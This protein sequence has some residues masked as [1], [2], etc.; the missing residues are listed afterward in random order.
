MT[1]A[2]SIKEAPSATKTEATKPRG[3]ER[4][5]HDISGP[6]PREFSQSNVATFSPRVRLVPIAIA[7][8][9]YGIDTQAV[10]ARVDNAVHP[11]H[12]RWAFNIGSGRAGATRELRFWVNEIGAP[13]KVKKFSIEQAV[14]EI[15]GQRQSFS[16]GDIEIQW[17]TCSQQISNLVSKGFFKEKDNRLTRASLETFLFTRWT[18]NNPT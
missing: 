13:E 16:R 15:L 4:Q 14:A 12:I 11:Q 18:G 9:L 1:S 10:M 8:W 2:T 6:K 7:R 5:D 17:I 3:Q